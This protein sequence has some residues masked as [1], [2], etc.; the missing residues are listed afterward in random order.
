MDETPLVGARIDVGRRVGWLLRT[1]RQLGPRG[2]RLSDIADHVGVSVALVHRV[3]MGLVRS[4]RVTTA[5]EQVLELAP[6]TLRAPID[7]TCRCFAYSLEDRDPG[8]TTATVAEMTRL[9]DRVSGTPTGGD[10]LEWARAYSQPVALG[11]PVGQAATLLMRLVDEMDRSVSG[12]YTTR[13][14]ALALMRCGPYGEVLLDVARARLAEPHVQMLADLMSAVG[15]AVTPDAL[16]WCL[17]LLS[18]PRD[19]VVTAACLGLENMGEISGD[20]LFWAPL[21]PRL[22]EVY[23][24]TEPESEPWRWLSHVLRLVPPALLK[25]GP[26]RPVR[27][28]APGAQTLV[29]A[30]SPPDAHWQESLVRAGE[31]TAALGLPDQPMLARLIHDLAF[32]PHETRAVTGYMLLTALPDLAAAV[33]E[34]VADIV[35][36]HP[37]DVI[38]ER[39]GRRLPG[40]TAQ[41]PPSAARWLVGPDEHLRRVGLRVAGTSGVVVPDEVLE[42]A[43]G[44][45][46]AVAALSAAGL[47]GHPLIARLADNELVDD[48]LRGAA[49]WWLRS[50]TRVDD[51]AG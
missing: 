20:P 26:V 17:D 28:L 3:E 24:A 51:G 32:G 49:R 15:E 19:R 34:Q 12:A 42:G 11:L 33:A 21:V 7:I 22:L 27:V 9:L 4:G 43:I 14:E 8:P 23:N 48:D 41:M 46:D 25:P 6:G 31:V 37:D 47:S 13:Y 39:A 36:S 16:A 10:W 38:R 5:Y 29:G 50:G 30:A 2:I 18:D 40:F 1:A 35:Q 44:A 45:G